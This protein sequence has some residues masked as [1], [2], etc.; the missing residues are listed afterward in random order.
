MGERRCNGREK[1]KWE[2]EGDMGVKGVMGG[3]RC[4][5]SEMV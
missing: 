3:R 1:V 4:N 5:G 2:G